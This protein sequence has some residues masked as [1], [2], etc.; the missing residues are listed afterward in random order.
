MTEPTSRNRDRLPGTSDPSGPC[1]RCSRP[2]NFGYP[3]SIELTFKG[4][5]YAVGRAG[6]PERIA[7]RR[8]SVLECSYCRQRAA[9]VEAEH[10]DRGTP[11]W[12]GL[13]WWAI[14][15]S[16]ELDDD[17]PDDVIA[18]YAKGVAAAHST[19]APSPRRS[20]YPDQR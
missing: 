5:V 20:D 1:P 14:P 7:S 17:V 18:A 15:G 9:V 3:G 12:R 2:S 10:N 13:H 6:G 16:T 4:G 8:A 11:S 19:S